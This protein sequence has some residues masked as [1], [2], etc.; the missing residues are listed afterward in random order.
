[1]SKRSGIPRPN[2]DEFHAGLGTPHQNV[3]VRKQRAEKN[4]AAVALGRMG[5]LK[6]GPARRAALSAKRR[7]A[8]ASKAAN[9]RWRRHRDAY[10]VTVDQRVIR[11]QRAVTVVSSGSSDQAVVATDSA[12]SRVPVRREAAV[13]AHVR[14]S[15]ATSA[16]IVHDEPCL[17]A[18]F[19]VAQASVGGPVPLPSL[20]G[21]FETFRGAARFRSTPLREAR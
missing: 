8:I 9:A 6:G 20:G 11:T 13:W 10:T 21:A 4:P 1:M 19:W 7:R 2:D 15:S 3:D 16:A 5:G 12:P 14:G 17:G 18:R